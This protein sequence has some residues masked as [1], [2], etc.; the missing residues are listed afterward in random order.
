MSD[1]GR[2]MAMAERARQLVDGRGAA[3]VARVI[4]EMI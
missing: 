4:V 2:R 3:R 1:T